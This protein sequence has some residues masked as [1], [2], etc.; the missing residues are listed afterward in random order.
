MSRMWIRIA[1]LG[2]PPS[3][4]A[5]AGLPGS[6]AIGELVGSGGSYSAIAAKLAG[7]RSAASSA[8]TA[9]EECPT[10]SGRA[11]SPATAGTSA[12]SIA[13]V[14]GRAIASSAV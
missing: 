14:C 9:P 2:S 11:S 13:I 1:W 3:S 6:P 10:S 4:A 5:R 8:A 12:A 7:D